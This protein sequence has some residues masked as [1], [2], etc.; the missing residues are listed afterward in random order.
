MHP[1]RRGTHDEL[2]RR[3]DG[4]VVGGCLRC[5]V[6]NCCCRRA[7]TAYCCYRSSWLLTFDVLV[8]VPV[9]LYATLSFGG[10]RD[11]V[12]V[13]R[14]PRRRPQRRASRRP[15]WAGRVGPSRDRRRPG[16]VSRPCRSSST[17]MSAGER[18]Q[19][20]S[21]V[22]KN[23][24][25]GARAALHGCPSARR[26]RHERPGSNTRRTRCRP[27]GRWRRCTIPRPGD[28]VSTWLRCPRGSRRA[29]VIGSAGGVVDAEVARGIDGTSPWPPAPIDGAGTDGA[30]V[31][32]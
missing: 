8:L 14:P 17:R 27:R 16:V 10:A 9:A 2:L 21:D 23:P 18:G 6:I 28:Q 25:Q 19:L 24:P 20:D 12:P 13:T 22:A 4:D 26:R 32:G 11:R 7:A 3:V 15:G 29:A 31:W 5:V 1:A 30:G